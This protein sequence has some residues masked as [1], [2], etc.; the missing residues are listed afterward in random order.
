MEKNQKTDTATL[1]ENRQTDMNQLN[2]GLSK[3]SL[4]CPSSNITSQEEE[5]NRQ[6]QETRPRGSSE[7]SGLPEII[8]S[9]QD[10]VDG[11]IGDVFGQE[12]DTEEDPR[13]LSPSGSM[14]SWQELQDILAHHRPRSNS[15][16]SA[17]FFPG[18]TASRSP[19]PSP[20]ISPPTSPNSPG[21][22]D[23]PD[24][25]GV[26]TRG[27]SHH[28]RTISEGQS[29]SG[30][31]STRDTGSSPLL[32]RRRMTSPGPSLRLKGPKPV[33]TSATSVYELFESKGDL[34]PN[35]RT[36][37][38][39]LER[40]RIMRKLVRSLGP[41]NFKTLYFEKLNNLS[42]TKREAPKSDISSPTSSK[43]KRRVVFKE[44]PT[45]CPTGKKRFGLSLSPEARAAMEEEYACAD[46]PNINDNEDMQTEENANT[47]P[48]IR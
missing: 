21:S 25:N 9:H 32:A 5:E 19:S 35:G 4:G 33:S 11:G 40:S 22:E 14:C 38:E 28:P 3:V 37:E 13:Y 44:V 43:S 48:S 8:I 7:E 29:S 26:R 39:L 42:E 16:P 41:E 10:E 30:K 31:T 46:S 47:L 18:R 2:Q 17:F 24:F 15:L 1:E 12:D 6:P 27:R 20:S 23:E 45:F 34:S 36:R